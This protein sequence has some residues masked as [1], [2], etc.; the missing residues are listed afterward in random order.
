MDTGAT[1]HLSA[2][3]GNLQTLF[4]LRLYPSILVGNGSQIPVTNMGHSILPTPHRPLHLHNVLVTPNIIKNLISIRK[5]TRDNDCSIEFDKCGFSMKDSWTK[6]TLLRCDSSG[7]LHPFHC[8]KRS[9]QALLTSSPFT[10]HQR[11]GHPGNEVLRFLISSR[12]ISCNKHVSHF[13][14][15]ECQL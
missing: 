8:L 15:N 9:P 4:N 10:W 12:L 14:C 3:T 2:G 7:E 5:F 11:L 13:L 6:Q 1:N